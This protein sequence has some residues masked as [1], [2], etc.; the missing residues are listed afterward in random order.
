M[1][2]NYLIEFYPEQVKNHIVKRKH[3]HTEK[4]FRGIEAPKDKFEC[5]KAIEKMR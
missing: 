3:H 1:E 5:M 4:V 2:T